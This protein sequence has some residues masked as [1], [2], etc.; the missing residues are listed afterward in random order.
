MRAQSPRERPATWATASDPLPASLMTSDTAERTWAEVSDPI[1]RSLP[2][3]GG[4]AGEDD[5][6]LTSELLLVP[7]G[8]PEQCLGV[9]V[10]SPQE[11]LSVWVLP[12]AL[13]QC[14]HGG[15]QPGDIGGRLLGRRVEPEV[16]S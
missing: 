11:T 3:A 1:V 5:V 6:R 15:R 8:Q 16:G 10:G 14:P 12:D 9:S 13:E 4:G 7:L 2:A